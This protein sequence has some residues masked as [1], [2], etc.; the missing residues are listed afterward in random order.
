MSLDSLLFPVKFDPV[1]VVMKDIFFQ[2][3]CKALAFFLLMVLTFLALSPCLQGGISTW[4]DEHH[5]ADNPRIKSLSAE[6]VAAMF[7][8]TL[9]NTYIPLTQLSF[10]ID[11]ALV[12]DNPFWYHL[13]NL[14]LHIVVVLLIFVLGL[15]LSLSPFA[16]FLA[17]LLFGIHPMHVE[18]V[19]WTTERKDVLYSV[20]YVLAMLQYIS[21]IKKNSYFHYAGALLCGLLSILAKP[22]ALSLP[23]VLMLL[24][25]FLKRPGR[26]FHWLDKIPFVSYMVPIAWMTFI[27]NT[28]MPTPGAGKNVLILIWTLCFYIWKF[29]FPVI[30][31]PF[32]QLPRPVSLAHVQ[33]LGALISLLVLC[34]GL[35]R[36]QRHRWLI[37]AFGY[38]ILSIF[39]LLRY[40]DSVQVNVVADRFMYLPSLGLCLCLGSYA[41]SVKS[42][43]A[44]E[45]RA[46]RSFAIGALVGGVFLLGIKTFLQARVWRD[47]YAMWSYVLKHSPQNAEAAFGLGQA[48]YERS[49]PDQALEY[50]RLALEHN[51]YHAKAHNNMGDLLYADGQKH[52]AAYHFHK[53][54]RINPE[55][56]EAQNNYGV[57]L[58][59]QG[60]MGLGTF[61]IQEARRL[62]PENS[63]YALSL[64]DAHWRA[65]DFEKAEQLFQA[66]YAASPLDVRVLN[67][68]GA[69]AMDRKDFV[70][71]ER[72]FHEAIRVDPKYLNARHNLQILQ[73][74]RLEAE[75]R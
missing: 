29:F 1:C 69:L 63:L 24:D 70:A 19:V 67:R 66:A 8:E 40:D 4:D 49:D 47:D 45:G 37:F 42:W 48:L 32:Y 46:F 43:V 30:L 26:P 22:M 56:A 54:I 34:A 38:Y 33:Y 53:A 3:S 12:R 6:N 18:S 74:K 61:H 23:L 9:L 64:G 39:F 15:R 68:L 50:Y 14:L 17:A 28:G 7:Q 41:A 13:H 35:Y 57:S 55:Y 25:W 44:R 11:Y 75:T 52:T 2:N 73:Q 36:F 16:A 21:Y 5:L 10:A 59:E 31:L 71:A 51:P 58:L 20:F 72:Y 65:G 27:L 62:D 60:Q